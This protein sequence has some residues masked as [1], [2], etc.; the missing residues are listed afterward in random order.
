MIFDE[1]EVKSY[2]HNEELYVNVDQFASHLEKAINGFSHQSYQI[3]LVVNMSEQE[4]AFITGLIE[5]M[6]SV[7]FMLKHANDE[8]E[9]G[10]INTV[11][12]F[13]NKLKKGGSE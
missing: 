13:L 8:H 2:V 7:L 4:K 6:G 3:S 1:I 11:E 9:I 12:E 5:G 10:T